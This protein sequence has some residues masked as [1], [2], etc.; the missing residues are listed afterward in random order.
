MHSPIETTIARYFAATRAPDREAWVACFASDGASHDPVGAPPH[1]GHDALRKFFDSIVGLVET[2]GL[3][4]DQVYVCGDQAGVKWTGRGL[5]KQG[6]PY[7]FEGID[8]FE[9]DA[10]GKIV[11]LKAYWDPAKLMAQLG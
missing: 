11:T 6:K 2:I 8:V 9:C 4:E 3:H 10:T 5:T 1:V 7:T